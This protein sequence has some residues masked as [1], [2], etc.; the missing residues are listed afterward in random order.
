MKTKISCYV[1]TW[2]IIILSVGFR[3]RSAGLTDDE[4]GA[5]VS[6]VSLMM[7]VMVFIG[8]WIYENIYQKWSKGR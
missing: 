5:A 7:A 8:L 6:I 4:V 3:L 2:A 1:T